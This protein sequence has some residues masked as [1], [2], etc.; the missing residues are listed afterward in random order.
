MPGNQENC[1]SW[2][3]GVGEGSGNLPKVASELLN[4]LLK[5]EL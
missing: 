5:I 1:L 4:L 2:P 3:E